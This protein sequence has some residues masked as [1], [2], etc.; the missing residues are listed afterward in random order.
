MTPFS[1][2]N[3]AHPA[4]ESEPLENIFSLVKSVETGREGVGVEV[5]LVNFRQAGPRGSKRLSN[6]PALENRRIAGLA[7]KSSKTVRTTEQSS[8]A[9]LEKRNTQA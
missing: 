5:K 2:S 3:E 8:K 4:G 6:D 1:P 7:T 9:L